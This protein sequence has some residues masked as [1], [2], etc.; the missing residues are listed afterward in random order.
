MPLIW[1]KQ[2]SA[3]MTHLSV[4]QRS[5]SPCEPGA[6]QRLGGAMCPSGDSINGGSY[7]I[8][9]FNSNGKSE[10]EMD[11]TG[12]LQLQEGLK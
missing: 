12:I 3:N 9:W 2:V 1:T 8:G 5:E 10:T 11:D 7:K 4:R 6:F